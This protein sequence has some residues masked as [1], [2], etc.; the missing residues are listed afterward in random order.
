MNISNHQTHFQN[1]AKQ[2]DKNLL[3]KK[4]IEVAVLNFGEDCVVLKI[5]KKSWTNDS[6]YPL[7]STSKIFFSVWISDCSLKEQKILYNIHALKLRQLK[8]FKI[9]SRK[10]AEDFRNSF[11]PFLPK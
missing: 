9:E 11:K 8:G 4:K 3:T 2:L 5:Y 10:F 1:S 6:E 7:N